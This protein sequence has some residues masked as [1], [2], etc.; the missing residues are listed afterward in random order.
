MTL[1]WFHDFSGG[2]F[3]WLSL[4]ARAWHYSTA[5][6][7]SNRESE[8]IWPAIPM[9][10][11]DP[12]TFSAKKLDPG[13]HGFRTRSGWMRIVCRRGNNVLLFDGVSSPHQTHQPEHPCVLVS[14][15]QVQSHWA[16]SGKLSEWIVYFQMV[17]LFC[18]EYIHLEICFTWYLIL[19]V[20]FCPRGYLLGGAPWCRVVIS[21]TGFNVAPLDP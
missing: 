7:T 21:L 10:P 19:I 11:C 12:C 1:I 16:G 4:P 17:F 6:T 5:T 9:D 15:I 20:F 8:G 18:L 14:K 13:G 2:E 3:L